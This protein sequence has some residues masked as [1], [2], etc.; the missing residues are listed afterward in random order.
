MAGH[1]LPRRGVLQKHEARQAMTMLLPTVVIVLS[2]IA[3]PLLANFWISIKPISLGDLRPPKPIAREQVKIVA[4]DSG[5]DAIVVRYRVRNSSRKTPLSDIVLHDTLA[6]LKITPVGT[7]DGDACRVAKDIVCTLPSLAA[8]GR[9]LLLLTLQ[10]VD[11][12]AAAAALKKDKPSMSA[13]ADAILLNATFSWK[14]YRAL[15]RADDFWEVIKVSL[16]YT[17]G[18][19][20]GALLLGLFAALL[21]AQPFRGRA[22][23][24][25]L[26]LFPY[27]APVIAVAFTWV[28]LFDPFSGTVNALLVNSG[29]VDEPISF[30]GVRAVPFALFGLTFNFPLALASVI[31]F[32]CWRYFPLAFLFIL[33]RMQSLNADLDDAAA[34]DGASPLQKFYHIIMP[35]LIG[36]MSVMFLLRFIWTFNKFD[37]IFLLTGGASGTRTLVV[38]VY[39][40]AFALSNIGAGAA[41]AVVVFFVLMFCCLLYFRFAPKGE[42]W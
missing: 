22:I 35:Q 19:T 38:N 42:G 23:W 24:R 30:F 6:G 1:S 11:I 26:L 17:I 13:E 37:D 15:F 36:I 3:F 20:G 5:K 2:V 39:E 10:A 12:Q 32:E 18:G 34:I 40:Q 4:T 9:T 14:N 28:I 33:A 41:A 31:A 16:I 8:G 25:G 21:M 27:V 7:D 29:A